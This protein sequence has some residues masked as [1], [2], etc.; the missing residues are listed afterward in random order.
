MSAVVVG[1]LNWSMDRDKEGHRTYKVKWLVQS[2][3]TSDGPAYALVASGLPAIGSSWNLGNDY[4][5]WARCWPTLSAKYLTQNERGYWW[6]VEQT[7]STKPLTRCQ[8]TTIENP[9]NEPDR[10]S[11]GFSKYTRE[12]EK[13]RNGDAIKT[14]SLERIRGDQVTFDDNRPTVTIEKNVLTLPLSDIAEAVDTVNS[15]SMWGLTSRK[16]KLTNVSWSRELYGTCTF[17]YKVSYEFEVD[18]DTFDRTVYDEGTRVLVKGGNKNDP[19]DFEL[20]KDINGEN[21]R[22][23]LDGNGNIL[24]AGDDPVEIDIEYYDET[25]FTTLGIPTT[26]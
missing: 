1:R 20:Y 22:V 13:D 24:P 16:V 21:T 11:G 2:S 6:E 8:D 15:N 4:D 3:S 17:Y 25:N 7:F 10:I 9:I 18:Y 14:S 12:V 19:A 5:A 23:F 26:L